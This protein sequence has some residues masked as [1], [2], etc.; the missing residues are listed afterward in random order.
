MQRECGE[1]VWR[2]CVESVCGECAESVESVWRECVER[3][4]GEEVM[5]RCDACAERGHSVEIIKLSYTGIHNIHTTH[6]IQR[7]DQS[8]VY[9]PPS[10]PYHTP[11]IHPLPECCM[12]PRPQLCTCRHLMLSQHIVKQIQGSQLTMQGCQGYWQPSGIG[13]EGCCY[14]DGV[15][16]FRYF[17]QSVG[18]IC[19]GGVS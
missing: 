7:H 6:Y 19:G 12:K 14:C 13:G 8:P 16:G 15:E 9:T 2:V 10:I 5:S 18:G 3:M 17:W 4:C 11:P 1:C